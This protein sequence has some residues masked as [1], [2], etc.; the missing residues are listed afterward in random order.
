MN[1]DSSLQRCFSLVTFAGIRLCST[2]LRSR[3]GISVRLKSGLRLNHCNI[4][5]LFFFS[6]S[7]VSLL[8]WMLSFSR[9]MTQ[10]WSSIICGT[11]V[12]IV[13]SRI[14]CCSEK[15]M[16]DSKTARFPSYGHKTSTNHHPSTTVPHSRFVLLC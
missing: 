12:L 16:V 2:I 5:T 4:F 9:G 3:H 13:D 14:L 10:F 11:D 1:F 15:I 6:H 8:L 7:A